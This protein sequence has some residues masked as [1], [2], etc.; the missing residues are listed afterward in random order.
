MRAKRINKQALKLS[1][2]KCRICGETDYATLD[3]HRIIEG[4]NNGKYHYNNTVVLCCKCHRKV[5]DNQLTIKGYFLCSNGK[6]MLLIEQDGVE[7]FI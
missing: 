3:V 5:H 6:Y 7:N 4:K 2:G 1:Q